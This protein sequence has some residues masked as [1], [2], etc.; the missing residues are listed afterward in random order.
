MRLPG[1]LPVVFF[2]V[3]L[4]GT[5][6]HAAAAPGA[7]TTPNTETNA[8]SADP[9][10]DPAVGAITRWVS[11]L[12]QTTLPNGLRVVMAP[13][14]ESPTVSV[15]VTYDVGSRNEGPGQSGFAH[16]FEHM[17]FQGS[18]NVA[19]GQHFQLVTARGG[20]LN[21]TTSTDRTNYFETLP[22]NE[23]ELGLWLEADRMRWLDISAANFENQRAVVKE[24]YR[25]RVEN[26][27]YRPAL[28]QLE[29]MIFAGYA[30]YEHPT[31]GSMEDLGAAK[32]EWVKDF[33]ARFYAPNNAVLSISGGFDSDQAVAL[34]RKYFEPIPS[35]K[36]TSFHEPAIPAQPMGERRMEVSD[37]NAKTEAVMLGWRI[38]PYRDRDHYALEMAARLLTDGESSLL[39][40]KLVRKRPLARDVSA[41][42]YDH[43][44]PDAFVITAEL[45]QDSKLAD[46]EQLIDQEL[47]KLADKGPTDVALGRARQRVKSSFVFG[48]QSNQSRATNL[49]EYATYF[50]DPRLIARDLEALLRVTPTDVRNGVRRYLGKT[51]RAVVSVRPSHTSMPQ[52]KATSALFYPVRARDTSRIEYVWFEQPSNAT[53]ANQGDNLIA[54]HV[55]VP[56]LQPRLSSL[57]GAVAVAK[58][59]Q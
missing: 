21:G 16:L 27:A 23:L 9:T 39:Y 53:R 28:I 38:P 55:N 41:Y 7:A 34:I 8:S 54:R 45:N 37:V 44:G 31:I 35:A 20:Q 47:G 51:S 50:G 56:Q 3:W 14:A 12:S 58:E 22:A 24:E 25:M 42:T 59:K 26:A 13:D 40:E 19:K 57:V 10:Q 5:T 17:M 49:G 18:R 33:H 1:Y 52:P 11:G 15:C 43:R 6:A 36:L 48:L 4:S 29:R 30:P 2:S 46:V 32:L